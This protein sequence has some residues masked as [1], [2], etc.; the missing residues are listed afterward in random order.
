MPASCVRAEATL[1]E[2]HQ[3][4]NIPALAPLTDTQLLPL[5]SGLTC[6]LEADNQQRKADQEGERAS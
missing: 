4:S 6:P 1:L 2:Q 3:T 5:I